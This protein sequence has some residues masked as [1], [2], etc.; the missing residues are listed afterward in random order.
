MAKK[1]KNFI[2]LCCQ[3]KNEMTEFYP[4]VLFGHSECKRL[5][6]LNTIKIKNS[7]LLF[8]VSIFLRLSH[9]P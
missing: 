8:L 5:E 9:S 1:T 6:C 7:C 3:Y 2:F 4:K